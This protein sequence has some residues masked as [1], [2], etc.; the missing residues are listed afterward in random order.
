MLVPVVEQWRF[1]GGG[2]A[3]GEVGSVGC[4]SEA[5]GDSAGFHVRGWQLVAADFGAAEA[6][7]AG[8]SRS[9]IL[10]PGRLVVDVFL[11]GLVERRGFSSSRISCS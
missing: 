11:A 8:Q 10:E 2:A 3:A 4:S 5:A 7:V 9:V 1:A 6:V